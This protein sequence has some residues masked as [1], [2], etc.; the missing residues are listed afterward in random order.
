MSKRK[1][2][3]DA[4]ERVLLNVDSILSARGL[5][6]RQLA[7]MLEMDESNLSKTLRN[8]NSPRVCQIQKIADALEVDIS[9]IF[10]TPEL[11]HM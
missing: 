3:F 4:M 9:E 7:E 5:T 8:V 6:R 11:A 10:K 1:T 2:Q